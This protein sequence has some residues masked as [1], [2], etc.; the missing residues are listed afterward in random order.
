MSAFFLG[1]GLYVYKDDL[2]DHIKK[3]FA[4]AHLDPKGMQARQTEIVNQLFD[5]DLLW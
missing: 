4:D 3:I 2:P 1:F 5:K